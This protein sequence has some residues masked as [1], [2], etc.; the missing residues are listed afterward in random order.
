MAKRQISNLK[1]IGAFIHCA[2]CG[3]EYMEKRKRE[4][5]EVNGQSPGDYQKVEVGWTKIGLQVWCRRHN[6]NIA[7][8]DFE[9]K[10]HPANLTR[11]TGN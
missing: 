4:D 1:E 11:S 7:H 9:G 2:L 8:V 6:C 10:R 3:Q 5:P